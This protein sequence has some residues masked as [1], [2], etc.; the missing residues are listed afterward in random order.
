[1]DYQVVNQDNN[2][3]FLFLAL[4]AI[5]FF[6]YIL[7]KID[8][9]NIKEDMDLREKMQSLSYSDFEPLKI[10]KLDKSSECKGY[11][12]FP[13]GMEGVIANTSGAGHNFLTGSDNKICVEDEH[14]EFLSKRGGNTNCKC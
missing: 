11:T 6:V 10:S 13:P 1:M 7:P 5:I 12:Q 9:C 4:V 3:M 8:E 14:L 2:Q